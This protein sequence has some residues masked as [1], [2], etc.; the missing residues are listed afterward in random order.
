MTRIVDAAKAGVLRLDEHSLEARFQ[1]RVT[2][3]GS[4][5]AAHFETIITI[6]RTRV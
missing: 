2:A 3:F 6:E 4:A 5:C 1:S